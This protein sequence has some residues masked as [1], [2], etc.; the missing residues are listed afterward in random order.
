MTSPEVEARLLAEAD[1]VLGAAPKPSYE[2]VHQLRY[3]EGLHRG[4]A[5]AA[6]CAQGVGACIGFP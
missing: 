2:Q 4:V 6:C 5:R 1:A 3:G